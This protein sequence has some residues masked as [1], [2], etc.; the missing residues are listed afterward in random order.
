MMEF[1]QNDWFQ[2]DIINKLI[3]LT[4]RGTDTIN[5]VI[6]KKYHKYTS[7]TVLKHANVLAEV[8]KSSYAR[9]HNMMPHD[10]YIIKILVRIVTLGEISHEKRSKIPLSKNRRLS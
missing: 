5:F 10:A 7:I 4:K 6:P 2:R 3:I 8:N 9:L 1:T